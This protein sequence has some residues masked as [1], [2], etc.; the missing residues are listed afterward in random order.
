MWQNEEGWGVGVAKLMWREL[1]FTVHV[2]AVT[3]VP[4]SDR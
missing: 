2:H 1:Q 3:V 4:Q